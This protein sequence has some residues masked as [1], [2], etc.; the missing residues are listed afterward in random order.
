[1]KTAKVLKKV[2]EELENNSKENPKKFI[3]KNITT[4]KILKEGDRLIFL[5][6]VGSSLYGTDTK[7][8]DLD[9]RG[10]FLP[11]KD[12]LILNETRNVYGKY[13]TSTKDNQKN[14][15]EDIDLELWSLQYFFKKIQ[16]GDTNAFDLLLASSN[17]QT[18]IYSDYFFEKKVYNNRKKLMGWKAIDKSFL[19]YAYGKMKKYQSRNGNK[20]K[21]LRFILEFLK[22]K[23]NA[24]IKNHTKDLINYLNNKFDKEKIDKYLKIIEKNDGEYLLINETKKFPINISTKNLKGNIQHWYNS[25]CNT[26]KNIDYKDF[27]HAFRM[28]HIAKMLSFH[29]D[30]NFPVNDRA[31]ERLLK[32]KKGEMEESF[33]E[34]N[35]KLKEKFENT[36]NSLENCEKLNKKANSNLIKEII[37]SFY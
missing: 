23:E 27:Y 1:M 18:V 36:K 16:K 31:K 34:L 4:E 30:F 11:S 33:E 15:K 2:K 13:S 12:S 7:N 29:G 14:G 25:Y 10:M 32:I 28:L 3:I 21:N 26:G 20:V 9:I 6:K 5:T 37:L 8:S 17:P 22:G 35:E 24:K 19:G